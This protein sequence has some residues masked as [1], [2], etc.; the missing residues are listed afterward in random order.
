MASKK[1]PNSTKVQEG[2]QNSKHVD[3]ILPRCTFEDRAQC[4]KCADIGVV[5][6]RK[7]ET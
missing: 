1:L 2:I 4:A 5:G 7:V 6:G 3:V